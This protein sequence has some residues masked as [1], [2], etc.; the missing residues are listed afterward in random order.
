[1]ALDIRTLVFVLGLTHVIQF[2]VFIHQYRVNRTLRGVGWWLLWSGVEVLAF[3]CMLLRGIP[4]LQPTAIIAQNGLLVLGVMFFYIG[5]LRFYDRKENRRLLLSIYAAYLAG[6]C[7]FLF[8]QDDFNA[9]GIIISVTLA[10]L[11]FLSARVLLVNKTR[12]TA[13]SANLLAAVCIAHGGHFAF[14]FAVQ[15]AAPPPADFFAPTLFNWTA[16]LDAII[17]GLLWTLGT[18]LM[19]NQR[20]N[21]EMK[22]ANEEME[23]VFN[24]SPDAAVISRLSDGLIVNI[25]DGFLALT[26][27]RREECIGKTTLAVHAWKN[28]ADREAVVRELREKGCCRS[29][30][31]VFQRKDGSEL[32]GLISAAVFKL[33]DMPHVI[34]VIRDITERKQAEAGIQ[35][36]QALS[37]TIID[38]IPGTFYLLD[39]HGRYTRWNSYQR[40]EILGK[41]EEQ[42][43][44]MNALDT[45]HPEDR[46]LIQGRIA[47]V[48]QDG[49]EEAVEGRV[50]LRGGPAFIWMLMTGRR[51]TIAGRPFLVGTGIDI[52]ERKRA[53]VALRQKS[54]ALRASNV[55]L[56]QFNRAMVG[57]ELRM[58]EL[59]QEINELCGRLGEPP[60]HETST[61]RLP[62]GGPA[63]TPP[64]GGGA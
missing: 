46:A 30:E 26:G 3:M 45:I 47:N 64:G 43:A 48:L 37:N 8:G 22:E 56:E 40:D 33:R 59:K 50:L 41:P 51:M 42:M 53:E 54:E 2:A 20:L 6:L 29:Y 14:R 11:A 27:L 61:D 23:L 28:P 21:A 60:R 15:L 9:R 25:N 7:Y 1:M 16:L 35:G 57:R 5:L 12:P 63:P 31:A 24:T 39:E 62:G 17:V 13:A 10:M 49:K 44:G 19:I 38:S 32:F 34:S 58:I 36:A 55:E 18:I 4:A 52:T